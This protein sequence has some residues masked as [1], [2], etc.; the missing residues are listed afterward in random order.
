MVLKLAGCSLSLLSL[1][2]GVIQMHWGGERRHRYSSFT[3]GSNQHAIA[4]V[5]K[6]RWK[7]EGAAPM[8]S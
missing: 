8:E 5:R 1:F 6:S 3:A 2:P 4:F 7:L